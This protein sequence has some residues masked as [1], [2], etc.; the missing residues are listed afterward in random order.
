[1]NYI[2]ECPNAE[3]GAVVCARL[4]RTWV[5]V[6]NTTPAL[7]THSLQMPR[8]L[9]E[10]ISFGACTR[11]RCCASERQCGQACAIVSKHNRANL[12]CTSHMW[13]DCKVAKLSSQ[14]LLIWS[15]RHWDM[16]NSVIN[17][18][19][20]AYMSCVTFTLH[21]PTRWSYVQCGEPGKYTTRLSMQSRTLCVSFL[22]LTQTRKNTNQKG[23]ATYA[24]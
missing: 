13:I 14:N 24:E 12:K 23:G 2:F 6:H 5:M 10:T 18:L 22:F 21:M 1:M 17:I 4:W 8:T 15:P 3:L 11:V 19:S 16:R 20:C 7:H 9:D